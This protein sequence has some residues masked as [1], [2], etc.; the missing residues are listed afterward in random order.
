MNSNTNTDAPARTITT[1]I[2]AKPDPSLLTHCDH[3]V[4]LDDDCGTCRAPERIRLDTTSHLLR[5]L[6]L[7]G[8]GSCQLNQVDADH[9]EYVRA[10]RL[11][12]RILAALRRKPSYLP[13]NDVLSVI[14]DC[15]RGKANV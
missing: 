6:K 11:H 3:G 1:T 5:T 14:D 15:F 9:V 13:L 2:G 10:D 8:Y 4:S 7:R 12:E